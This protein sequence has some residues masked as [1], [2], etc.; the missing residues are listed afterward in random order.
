MGYRFEPDK[1]FRWKKTT[2]KVTHVTGSLV[3]I[4]DIVTGERKNVEGTELVQAL[5]QGDLYFEVNERLAQPTSSDKTISTEH[6]Y[7]SWDVIKEEHR[8]LAIWRLKVIEPLL[9]ATTRTRKLVESRVAEMKEEAQELGYPLSAPSVYRWLKV[10]EESN[11]DIRSLVDNT[12]GRRGGAGNKRQSE[13]VLELFNEIIENDY[14]E[15]EKRFMKTVHEELV[16]QIKRINKK[17]EP[18]EQLKTPSYTTV[19][20]WIGELDPEKV[21]I[22]KFGKEAAEREL[23][24]YGKMKYPEEPLETVEIDHTPLDVIVLDG[25]GIPLGRLNFT[26]AIDRATRYPL[27]YYAGFDLGYLAVMECL[28][29]SIWPKNTVER[30]NTQH[31]WLAYGIPSILIT[32]NGPEFKGAALE[33]AC[34]TLGISLQQTERRKP[35][36]KASVER[37]FR[38]QGAGVIHTLP[39]TTFS[40]ILEKGDYDPVD[41]ACIFVD[42][43]DEIINL[44]LV[45]EYAQ[46]RH[47]GL[48]DIPARRWKAKTREGFIPNLPA[49]AEELDIILRPSAT[50]VLQHYGIEFNNLRYNDMGNVELGLLR[51]KMKGEKVNIKYNPGDLSHIYVYDPFQKP[52]GKYIKVPSLEPEYTTGLSLWQHGIIEKNAREAEGEVNMASLWRAREQISQKIKESMNRKAKLKTN[53]K[54]ARILEGGKPTRD[55]TGSSFIITNKPEQ[56]IPHPP[57][58]STDTSLFKRRETLPEGW[59]VEEDQLSPDDEDYT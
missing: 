49:N 41:Q 21:L 36:Q 38:T 40:N 45:D 44:F 55:Q 33:E 43:I 47:R 4:E 59:S 2:Y 25:N 52:G 7:P 17:R 6:K 48:K 19:T 13:E 34:L 23:R 11:G 10:Y 22:A 46:K 37:F 14:L 16:K 24:Q 9:N 42:Q 50:R 56:N 29:H 5:A 57:P 54:R 31:E 27:G 39:G 3:R 53:R 8:D 15:R 35:W 26:F 1:K 12:E 20:R 51:H 30:Y 32:D 28:R 18:S 58:D